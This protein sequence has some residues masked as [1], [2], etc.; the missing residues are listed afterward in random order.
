MKVVSMGN[1]KRK[2]K[3]LQAHGLGLGS[4]ECS[5]CRFKAGK[6]QS[7]GHVQQILKSSNAGCTSEQE[8]ITVHGAERVLSRHVFEPQVCMVWRCDAL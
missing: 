8:S 1:K 5:C 7:S 2:R 3:L 6:A 4:Q